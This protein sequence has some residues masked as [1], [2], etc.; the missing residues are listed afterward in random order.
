MVKYSEIIFII[1]FFAV[2]LILQFL[3]LTLPIEPLKN[4]IAS[5]EAGALGMQSAGSTIFFDSHKFEVTENCTGLLSGAILAAVIFSL[6]K[7]D[8]RKKFSFALI[9]ALGLFLLNFPRIYAVLWAAKAF[10]PESAELLHE[11]TW[12]TT[13]LFVI[14]IWYFGTKKILGI[15]NFGELI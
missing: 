2:F 11:I 5:T 8:L 4:F 9:G 10:N 3:I 15:K 12:I 13:A 6:R 1:K 7:P 14:I